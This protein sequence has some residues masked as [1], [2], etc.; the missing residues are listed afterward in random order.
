MIDL[1]YNNY[2]KS[3][4]SGDTWHVDI[5]PITRPIDSYFEETVNTIEYVYENIGN[6]K[7]YVLYS[8]GMDSEY[9]CSVLLHLGID[10]IPVII[11]LK[12]NDHDIAYAHKFCD[13]HNIK[14]KII[15]IDFLKF[16]ESGKMLDIAL[17]MKCCSYR[18]PATMYAML[19][20]DGFILLGNDPPF[21]R[22]NNGVWQLEE[23]QVI[24]SIF[25]FC[26][27]Y[28]IN[29]C[30]FLLSYTPEMMLSFLQD[31]IMVRVASDEWPDKRGTNSTK[32]HVYN[33][34]NGAFIMENRPKYIGY[35]KIKDIPE[36]VNHPD[37]QLLESYR[38]KWNGCFKIDH[39]NIVDQMSIV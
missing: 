5:D 6:E 29:G 16:V 37:I 22:R 1:L 8:G 28:N 21:M 34:N 12:Y 31:P 38:S 23:E 4:G 13:T 24:H 35:E 17:N 30:P 14:P 36:I 25:N 27:H 3:S 26:K 11:D 32:V 15:D 18:M 7:I 10:F 19:E 39:K 9:V 2:M 20:L 33:N